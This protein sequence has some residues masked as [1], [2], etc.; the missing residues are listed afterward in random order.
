LR[1]IERGSIPRCSVCGGLYKPDVVLFDEML[2]QGVF[3]LAQRAIERCDVLIVAGTSL[4]VA[5]VCDMPL[6]ALKHR[7]RLIVVNLDETYVDERADAVLHA[8]VAVA[9]PALVAAL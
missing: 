1:Q 5:P 7:A 3:W 9:L 8:D 2:P 4:E 6:L